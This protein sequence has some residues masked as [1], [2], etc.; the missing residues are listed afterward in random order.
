[1][2]T[3][4]SSVSKHHTELNWLFDSHQRA[5]LA[6]DLDLALA[7]LTTYGNVLH[8]HIDFE[9]KRLL[10][11]YADRAATDGTL[12]IFQSEHRELHE[13]FERLMQAAREL[14]KSRDLAGSILALLDE[15]AGFKQFFHQHVTREESL[16]FPR[17]DEQTTEEERRTCLSLD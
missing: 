7:Q 16:L 3:S 13:T 6:K 4:F 12:Q 5:L 15:E 2:N 11:L 17:L 10:P 1:M 8:R 14:H 9:E